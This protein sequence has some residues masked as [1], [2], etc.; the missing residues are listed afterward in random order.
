MS[1]RLVTSRASRSVCNSINSSSSSRSAG[2][3]P[4]PTC[5]R[6]ETAVLMEANG[7]RRSWEA[8]PMS[9]L[10]QRSISSSRRA[11]NACSDSS[12]RS[13]ASAA[14]LANVPSRLRSRPASSTS[15]STSRPTGWS[16]TASATETRRS[17]VLAVIP[18]ERAWPP[19]AVKLTTSLSAR[20]SP[21]AA[22]T[23]STSPGAR[24]P[25]PPAGRIRAVQRGVKTL[26]T[27]STMCVSSCERLR[28]PM[29]AWDSS[30]SR[31]V[32]SV[33]RRASARAARKLRRHLGHDEDDDQV[34]E[35]G[36]PVL[37][38]SDRERVVG[39]Q[40]EVVVAEEAAE[41][42]TT[43]GTKPAS[44]TPRSAG[45]TNSNAGMA[46]LTCGQGQQNG[47]HDTQSDEGREHPQN[48]SLVPSLCEP[49]WLHWCHCFPWVRLPFECSD[50]VGSVAK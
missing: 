27:V 50:V 24:A 40:E 2:S 35:Q 31:P 42:P 16:P 3:S 26:C 15:W 44:T 38:R 18:S 49:A 30:Y 12:A 41:A 43:P 21:A 19:P 6:L 23:C 34:D 13:R 17:S 32:S 39:G 33:R 14:W 4:A 11:R 8:A 46:V 37:R 45:R 22:A 10:R 20:R 25:R 9:A 36:D 1:S 48:P 29:S 47:E 28:S 7:V 5:R